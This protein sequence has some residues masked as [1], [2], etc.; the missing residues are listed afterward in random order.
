MTE[1][2]TMDEKAIETVRDVVGAVLFLA[3]VVVAAILYLFATPDQCGGESD[4]VREIP[5]TGGR[6]AISL[7][8]RLG[9]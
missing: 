6:Q 4:L 9:D 5:E 1:G 3:L 7:N 8:G 2:W